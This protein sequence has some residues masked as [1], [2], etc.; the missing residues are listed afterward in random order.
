LLLGGADL[1]HEQLEP[2]GF[3]AVVG[4]GVEHPAQLPDLLELAPLEEELLVAG[5][6]GVDVDGRVEAAL[7][8]PAVEPQLHVAGALE[9]LED[10]LVHLRAGLDQGRGQDGQRAALFDV[11]GRAEELLGRVQRPGV[12]TTGHDP[13]GGRGGQVV[14]PGQA[15]DAVEDDHDVPAHLDQ[16]LGPLDGQLGHLGVLVGRAVEGRG[17]HLALAPTGACR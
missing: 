3:L 10:D 1:V 7:G 14:G 13:A 17:D 11:A 9:L 8:E 4:Q 2:G 5:R 16:A 6:A 15:G 12:H